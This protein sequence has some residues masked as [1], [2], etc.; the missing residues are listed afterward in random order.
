MKTKSFNIQAFLLLII[1]SCAVH[2]QSDIPDQPL[3]VF[4]SSMQETQALLKAHSDSIIVRRN[5]PIQVPTAQKEQS[6]LDVYGYKYA[7]KKRKV[8]LI[9]ADDVLDIAWLLTDAD[10]ETKFI[11]YFKSKFGEPTHNT[12]E[13]T[14]FINDRVA[15]RNQPHEVLYISQR[16]VE[17]YKQFLQK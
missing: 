1:A 5:E 7:G 4:G 10:E 3:F 9:F 16:L 8:E 12:P 15:V 2:K 13:V 11:E 17:P 6:Q 14:F